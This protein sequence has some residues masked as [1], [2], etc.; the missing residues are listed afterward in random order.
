MRRLL[1]DEALHLGAEL[2]LFCGRQLREALADRVDEELFADRKAH[3]QRV[4]QRGAERIAGTPVAGDGLLHVDEQAA[5]DE[6]G[7]D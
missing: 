4:E 6:I 2:L 1:A 3:G 5:D 7:H